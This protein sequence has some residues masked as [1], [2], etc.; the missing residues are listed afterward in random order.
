MA[1]NMDR[2]MDKDKK[3]QKKGVKVLAGLARTCKHALPSYSANT[4]ELSS[5][6]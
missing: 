2:L 1:D 3:V 4:H 6:W 5:G